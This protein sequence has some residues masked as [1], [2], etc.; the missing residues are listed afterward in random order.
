MEVEIDTTPQVLLHHRDPAR[1]L[2]PAP[3]SMKSIELG[4]LNTLEVTEFKAAAFLLS[5]L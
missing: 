2:H 4:I 3:I 1:L 5:I